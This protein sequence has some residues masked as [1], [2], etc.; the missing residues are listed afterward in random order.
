MK[1]LYHPLSREAINQQSIVLRNSEDRAFAMLEFCTERY[2]DSLSEK[3]FLDIGPC[4][5]Y[6]LNEFSK[7]CAEVKGIENGAYEW[8]TIQIF[9]PNIIDSVEKADFTKRIDYIEQYDIV[10]LMSI[11]HLLIM[12]DEERAVEMLKKVDNRTKDIMFFD[13]AQ[14]G[15]DRYYKDMEGWNEETIQSWLL[16]NTTFDVC[17][18]LMKDKDPLFGRTLFVCYRN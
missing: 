16:D 12:D 15:E 3:T 18:P 9:Y 5:G 13:M 10:A 2:G 1:T 4:Y 17:Q 14:E 11:M 8:K 7:H 6:F